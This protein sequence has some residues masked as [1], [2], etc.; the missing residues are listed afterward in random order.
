[1]TKRYG[2][3][4]NKKDVHE[5]NAAFLEKCRKSALYAAKKQGWKVV[6]CSDGVNPLPINEIHK[7][8]VNI[9]KEELC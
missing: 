5:A 7:K 9:V 1:M 2:G 3:D 8:I 6:A 4:E